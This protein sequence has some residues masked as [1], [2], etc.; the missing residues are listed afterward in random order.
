MLESL[1]ISIVTV[2]QIK[3]W[4]DH[5]PVLIKVRQLVHNGWPRSI[6]SELQ[7]FHSKR[8]KLSIQDNCLLWGSCVVIPQ[9]GR[10]KILSLRTS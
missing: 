8:L 2:T 7:P 1:E 3:H 5:N 9:L 4:T 6:S 10:E